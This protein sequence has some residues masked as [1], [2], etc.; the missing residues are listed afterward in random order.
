MGEPTGL[1]H[2]MTFKTTVP[3]LPEPV[4]DNQMLIV[5]T[6]VSVLLFLFVTSILLCFIFGQHLH[7]RRTGTYGVLAAWRRLPRAFRAHPV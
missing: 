1:W 6:A 5:I 3:S 4:Q 7:Q 2:L